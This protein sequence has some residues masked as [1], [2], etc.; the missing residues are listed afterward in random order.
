[1]RNLQALPSRET[2]VL[3][4]V[5]ECRVLSEVTQMELVRAAEQIDA[6]LYRVAKQNHEA[7]QEAV[8]AAAMIRKYKPIPKV[9][10]ELLELV[11]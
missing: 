1:M 4:K 7:S 8:K 3:A 5:L 2:Q 10:S 9:K 11:T 6:N